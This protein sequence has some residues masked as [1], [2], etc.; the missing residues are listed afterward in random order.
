MTDLALRALILI[1]IGGIALAALFWSW[2][3][4]DAKF[5]KMKAE[6]EARLA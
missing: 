5:R 3:Q 6:M 1:P 4:E 2:R